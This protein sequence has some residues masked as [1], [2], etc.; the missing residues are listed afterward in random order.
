[1][2][3][4]YSINGLPSTSSATVVKIGLLPSLLLGCASAVS[5]P[6]TAVM[7][8]G[9]YDVCQH[10]V[11]PSAVSQVYF[12]NTL[13]HIDKTFDFESTVSHFYAK[14]ESSQESLGEAFE[15]VLVD[16]LWDLYSRT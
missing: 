3:S 1:M 15:R 5:F 12:F 9:S 10:S 7:G 6:A 16:N 13:S 8:A 11:T 4:A 14:L 2:S